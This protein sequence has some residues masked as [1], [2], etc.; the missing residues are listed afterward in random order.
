MIFVQDVWFSIRLP[1]YGT[2]CQ[3]RYGSKL[4]K[5]TV[6]M[7]KNQHQRKQSS[8]SEITAASRQVWDVLD[9]SWILE[10]DSL[11]GWSPWGQSAAVFA[12]QTALCSSPG[13]QF[14]WC[15]MPCHPVISAQPGSK[16][17]VWTGKQNNRIIKKQHHSP[18]PFLGKRSNL[19]YSNM[20]GQ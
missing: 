7:F 16:K 3:P 18:R 11:L 1:L 9:E 14:W 20:G 13:S 17:T 15:H 6:K 8:I 4:S 2:S 10:L 12:S 5:V 19:H